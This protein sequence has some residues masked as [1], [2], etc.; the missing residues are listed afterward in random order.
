MAVRDG[1]K[2]ISAAGDLEHLATVVYAA[3]ISD[4]LDAL[5]STDRVLGPDIRPVGRLERPLI[6]RAA[7]ARA[8]SVDAPPER[9][10]ATL[11]EAMDLL[12]PG[13]VWVVASG[14]QRRSA[15][16]GGLLATA[17]RARGAIGCIIDGAVRDSRELERLEFP[18]F[19]T[20]YSPA[21]SLGRD[22]IVEHGRPVI[23]AGVE[24]HPGDLIVADNDGVVAVPARL[25][26]RVIERA[27][28]KV[29]EEGE[30]RRALAN[31]QSTADA[32]AKYGIL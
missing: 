17:A 27:L 10:Y 32:F 20:G 21:D 22:E 2:L 23:C 29:D 16:F 24:I 6:G 3:V 9:P 5:G 7:T 31:G 13:E 19:A 8:V 11:L 25:E 14:G 26:R 28:A 4:A 18:T 15:I 12:S 1:D 30:M